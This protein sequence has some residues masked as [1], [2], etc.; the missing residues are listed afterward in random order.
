[1][2]SFH[3]LCN[4]D[5][6][7]GQG[8]SKDPWLCREPSCHCP[9]TDLCKCRRIGHPFQELL[10]KIFKNVT[11]VNQFLVDRTITLPAIY[12]WVLVCYLFYYLYISCMKRGELI[13]VNSSRF[14]VHFKFVRSC[15]VLCLYSLYHQNHYICLR[16]LYLLSSDSV[17]S[18]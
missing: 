2:L 4:A 6:N 14:L 1:M 10:S 13:C 12:R 11:Y 8:G 18:P 9:T 16:I 17:P 15:A 5:S 3:H 7:R